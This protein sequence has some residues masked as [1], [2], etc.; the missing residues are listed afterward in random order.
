MF[1]FNINA[2]FW[3]WMDEALKFKIVSAP[4]EVYKELV[5][6]VKTTDD[7]A[8]WI[9]TRSKSGLCIEPDATD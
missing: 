2:S 7:L 9:K 8:R 4:R 1:A 3:T 6:N 5:E